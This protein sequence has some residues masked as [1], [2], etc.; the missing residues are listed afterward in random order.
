MYTYNYLGEYRERISGS[1]IDS[2]EY[3]YLKNKV[4]L[5]RNWQ[6]SQICTSFLLHLSV[7]KDYYR[8]AFRCKSLP[9]MPSL[10][11]LQ[12][13]FFVSGLSV[14]F[15]PLKSCQ[16]QDYSWTLERR[17][18]GQQIV[19]IVLLLL[20]PSCLLSQDNHVKHIN[21]PMLSKHSRDGI[22]HNLIGTIAPI[23]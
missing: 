10:C 14:C 12:P 15:S 17:Y 3:K 11:K 16:L 2:K 13:R 6:E 18:F 20:L 21:K 8:D 7:I 1:M 5:L 9:E 4:T 23:I 19:M 22:T